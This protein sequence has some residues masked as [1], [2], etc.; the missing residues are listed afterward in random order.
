MVTASTPSS[1][2]IVLDTN[3]L[4]YA[5]DSESPYHAASKSLLDSAVN[6]DA[7]LCITSQIA[8]E[9]CAVITDRR[10]VRNPLDPGVAA[11]IVR[12][13]IALPGVSVLMQPIG[14]E[15]HFADL[16]EKYARV[17]PRV[18]DL[19]LVAVM[20]GNGVRRICTYNKRDFESIEGIEVLTL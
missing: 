16:L 19:F 15:L 10:R 2:T 14:A 13:L 4:V 3:V 20:R 9:F 18:F 1:T 17:G 12:R 11:S 6:E 5:V 7:G 8:A